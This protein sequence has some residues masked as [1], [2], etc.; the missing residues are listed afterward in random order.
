MTGDG[1]EMRAVDAARG[2]MELHQQLPLPLRLFSPGTGSAPLH[3]RLG[4]DCRRR[5]QLQVVQCTM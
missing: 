2:L 1:F 5:V 4:L 3:V